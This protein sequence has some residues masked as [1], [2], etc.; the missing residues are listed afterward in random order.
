MNRLE[1]MSELASLLQDVPEEERRDAMKYYND[2]FDE[3]GKE[4]EEEVIKELGSPAKVAESIKADLKANEEELRSHGE[5]S[6]T[7]YTDERFE[8]REVPGYRYGEPNAQ[9]GQYQRTP[10]DTEPPRTSKA[11]KII[12]IVAIILVASPVLIP[13][14][15]AIAAVAIGLACGAFAVVIGL[16]AAAVAIAIAGVSVFIV[17]LLTLVPKLAVGLALIGTGMI[18]TVLGVVGT[19]AM[20][21]LCC[22]AIP[23]IIHGIT[24]VFGKLFHRRAV[25]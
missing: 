21:K 13:V 15:L 17:G 18:L 7:G 20:V 5:F 24:W 8:S 1:Y 25:A 12:L 6:E 14:V 19:V 11:L 2:Y 3:A 23:G 16:V 4:N 22:V 9:N 10:E